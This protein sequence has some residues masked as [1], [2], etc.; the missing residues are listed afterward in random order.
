[1]ANNPRFDAIRHGS[2]HE[3]MFLRAAVAEYQ[4][5]GHDESSF[6]Q[7]INQ[8][9]SL[10]NLEDLQCL[11]ADELSLVCSRLSNCRILVSCPGLA[12]W[13]RKIRLGLP[14]DDIMFALR[15]DRLM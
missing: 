4:R 13:T 1:M 10:C 2:Q 7:L 8:Y 9:N 5:T 14:A 15:V 3:Q 11:N 6:S 12:S